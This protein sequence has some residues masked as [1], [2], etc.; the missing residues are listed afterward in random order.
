M[1]QNQPIPVQSPTT[2]K[3]HPV[4]PENCNDALH[5]RYKP[6][7]HTLMYSTDGQRGMVPN[8]QAAD[9]AKQGYKSSANLTDS[10]TQRFISRMGQ[11]KWLVQ[12]PDGKTIQFPDEF[13]DADVTREMSKL[14]GA[15]KAPPNP[16]LVAAE[17]AAT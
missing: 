6:T 1:A 4:P 10:D 11:P 16:Y 5:Q 3:I 17:A 13:T 8:E 2:G 14:Y 7:Q 9:Y 15:P 12:A